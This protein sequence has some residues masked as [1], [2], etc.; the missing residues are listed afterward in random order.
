MPQR[1]LLDLADAAGAN[2]RD[3]REEPQ[4]PISLRCCVPT[5]NTRLVS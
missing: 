3:G 1:H 5:W 2:Q 4:V